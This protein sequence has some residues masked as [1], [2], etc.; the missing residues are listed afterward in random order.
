MSHKRQGPDPLSRQASGDQGLNVTTRTVR[1][2]RAFV[3]YGGSVL[4]VE[5]LRARLAD[6]AKAARDA[7]PTPQRLRFLGSSPSCPQ[8]EPSERGPL[9]HAVANEGTCGQVGDDAAPLPCR[10]LG[11]I[12]TTAPR[13][14]AL[15]G[16]YR[17]AAMAL[18]INV[19]AL[20]D[21]HGIERI[22]FLT[23]TF[24]DH[25]VCV[26]EASRR[27]NSLATRVLNDRYPRGWIRV[28]ERQK[29]GRIHYHLLVVVHD[30]IRTGFDFEAVDRDDYRSANK[31][32]RREWAFWHKTA[33][34]YRFGRTEFMPIR[35]SSQVMGAYIGKYIAKGL[36]SRKEADKGARLVGISKGARTAT[37]RF[38]P[39]D[40]GSTQW[41]RKC[42]AFYL[43][44]REVAPEGHQRHVLSPDDISRVLGKRWAY[45]W[46][47]FILSLEPADLQV[48]F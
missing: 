18:Q 3:S 42:H 46:R 8:A 1:R 40:Y 13:P 36:E 26:K 37:T 25:V 28:M 34:S 12:Q 4:P 31:S 23:L 22:G 16:H 35:S 10:S 24:A 9:G 27:F 38:T 30:D 5:T 41:R 19:Q 21:T 29:S 7:P 43:W 47:P 45:D 32:I 11:A 48:P 39:T 44:L 33:K 20:I 6:E 14:G 15:N 17:R 2:P